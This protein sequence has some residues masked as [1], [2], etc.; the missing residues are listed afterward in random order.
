MCMY[1]RMCIHTYTY[2]YVYVYAYAYA[3]EVWLDILLLL[4]YK[5][6]AKYVSELAKLVAKIQWHLFIYTYPYPYASAYAYHGLYGS[7]S[8]CKSD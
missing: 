7:T 2:V 1:M 4:Y 6:T 3:Y 8:C 5:F